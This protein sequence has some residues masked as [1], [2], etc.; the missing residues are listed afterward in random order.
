MLCNCRAYLTAL[1]QV[2]MRYYE[3]TVLGMTVFDRI[4]SN[5]YMYHLKLLC[6][7]NDMLSGRFF[8][9]KIAYFYPA[10]IIYKNKENKCK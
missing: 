5:F 9:P 10:L 2:I 1:I 7:R 4:S 6:L 3:K 8:P